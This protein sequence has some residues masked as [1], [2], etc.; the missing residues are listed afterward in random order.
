MIFY[1]TIVV[2]VLDVFIWTPIKHLIGIRMNLLFVGVFVLKYAKWFILGF[3]VA[4]ALVWIMRNRAI[5]KVKCQ[6]SYLD[7]MTLKN[8]LKTERA[9]EKIQ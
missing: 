2:R 6:D 9:E 7:Y 5:K 1:K 8:T 3:A 4:F